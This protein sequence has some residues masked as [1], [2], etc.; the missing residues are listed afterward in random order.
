MHS[1][2]EQGATQVHGLSCDQISEIKQL[3][4]GVVI[5]PG[6]DP[7]AY[8][9]NPGCHVGSV[10]LTF[11]E[12]RVMPKLPIARVLFLWSY[13]FDPKHWRDREVELPKAPGLINALAHAFGLEL[14][15]QM[16]SGLLEDYQ[17]K[18]ENE[19]TVRGRIRMVEQWVNTLRQRPEVACTYEEYTADIIE[20]QLLKEAIRMLRASLDVDH[21]SAKIL[22]R[23]AQELLNVSAVRFATH[24]VPE[25]AY[26]PRSARYRRAIELARLILSRSSFEL[27]D[28]EAGFVR[29]RGFLFD[30]NRVFEEFVRTAL[31]EA[32]G[33]SRNSFG[34]A[35]SFASGAD[36]YLDS[37]R[38]VSLEPDL[39]WK[40]A[41][42][43]RFVGDVKYKKL[44]P[45]S[46]PNADIYQM[47]A[48][49][50]GT[51]LDTGML[52]YPKSTEEP[53]DR[54]VE[55]PIDG[56]A[57]RILVRV[58]DLESNPE[59]ILSKMDVLAYEIRAIA[60]TVSR[61]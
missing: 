2:K 30:M 20:N 11:G 24:Y 51:E 56:R 61:S 42:R 33:L 49:L 15:R 58:I 25:V 47:L 50:V 32:L 53:S 13:A 14:E 55:I 41:S 59:R 60:T 17:R 44:A 46:M 37:R 38:R 8:A 39:L 40:Q 36:L 9:V 28:Q 10:R 6:V 19:R 16:R 23:C 29:M 1:L 54:T 22:S 48:Y 7:G 3:I 4:P 43:L 45:S 35:R 27:D 18:E 57:R 26:R 34:S 12:L 31:R 21:S 52:I 5:E